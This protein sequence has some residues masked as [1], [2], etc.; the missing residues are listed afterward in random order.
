VSKLLRR[1]PRLL[2]RAV[3]SF[4][5]LLVVVA[6]ALGLSVWRRAKVVRFE[7]EAARERDE[8]RDTLKKTRDQIR[9]ARFA[10][11]TT[12]PGGLPDDRDPAVFDVYHP[13]ADDWREQPRFARLPRGDQQWLEGDLGELLYLVAHSRL[14]FA[15]RL[16]V[17]SEARERLLGQALEDNRRAEK[18][19][20]EGRCPPAV[21]R[22]RADLMELLHH[23][24]EAK[25]LRARAE[26]LL[27]RTVRD[28][29]L[30]ALELTLARKYPEALPLLRRAT[31]LE[32]QNSWAWMMLGFCH[33]GLNDYA[34]AVGAYNV[35]VSREQDFHGGYFN[36]GIAYFRGRHYAEA[37]RDF[38][39]ALERHPHD[40][41]ALHNRALAR[42]ALRDYRDALDDLDR[43]L[44]L[45]P[46]ASHLYFLR[47]QVREQSGDRKGAAED[48]R[49]G[50]TRS[51]RDVVGWN[52]LGNAYL[53]RRGGPFSG[54][55]DALRALAAFDAGLALDPD[56]RATLISKASVLAE[57]LG[58]Q[59]AAAAVLDHMIALYPNDF[60]AYSSRGVVRARLGDRAGALADAT[61]ALDRSRDPFIAYQVGDVYALTSR[62]EPADADDALYLLR[63]AIKRGY[64]ADL[65]ADDPDL[66]P[67]HH[68]PG[69][70]RL[71]DAV[72]R[73]RQPAPPP[74]P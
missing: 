27:L 49:R 2:P 35:C 42:Q 17:G 71:R 33:D 8:A 58:R 1:S 62:H 37:V 54:F 39:S 67:L 40:V 20:G 53:A 31:E 12:P 55:C 18:V 59:R 6:T 69:F 47:A 48:I 45:D 19:F 64:G 15:R 24:G 41:K 38:D 36:R 74:K 4:A 5:V 28:L 52:T 26:S 9:D 65:L 10:L 16:A 21:W 63:E 57:R 70:Q 13:R 7:I 11:T 22:Q 43:A 66:I 72:Q 32:P 51:L 68:L 25:N 3:V 46:A 50:M 61:A 60:E 30:E 73:P 29:Y 23:K 14:R 44:A 56:D 34:A